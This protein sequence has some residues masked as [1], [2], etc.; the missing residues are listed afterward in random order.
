MNDK[1]T[2][3]VFII[4]KS[5]S[6][7][8]LEDDTIGGFNSFLDN[9]RKENENC[10]IS[11]VL[12]SSSQKIL[13][14]HENISNIKD[15]TSKDYIASG[16]TALLD[17]LGDSINNMEEYISDK[18]DI[19]V[20]YIIIT[21]GKENSSRRFNYSSIKNM[22]SAKKELG[23]KFIFLAS[24]FDAWGEGKELGMS[25]E[26]CVDYH[27]DSIGIRK[28]YSCVSKAVA[29]FCKKDSLDNDWKER[30]DEDI[31]K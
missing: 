25:K 31:K 7:H 27:N 30:F 9:Q 26:D 16:T 23:W 10:N 20:M 11:T 2:E 24:N 22:V 19:N 3:V 4:D 12:F 18:K 15:L 13:H 29:C 17:A 21:D 14:S 1:V 5:G 28:T 6:M 8:G